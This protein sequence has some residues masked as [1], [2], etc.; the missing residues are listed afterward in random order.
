MQNKKEELMKK[1][2]STIAAIVLAAAVFAGGSSDKGNKHYVMKL[3]TQLN[4]TS[5]MVKGFKELAENVK[6]KTNGRLEIQVYPS[7]QLGTDEDVIEQA[8]QGVN[9]CVLTDAGRMGN[10]VHDIGIIG[11]AYFADKYDDVLKVTQGATFKGWVDELAT[12]NDI[13][14]LSFNW[15]DGSRSFYTHKPV[16]TPADLKGQRIRTPG[17]PAWAESVAALGG[18]PVAMPWNDTYSGIQSKAL[19][20]CEVQLTSAV[21]ARLYEVVKYL[22]KT[23][24][25]HLING[26]IV[27]EKWFKTLPADLQKILVEETQ[28]AGAKNAREVEAKGAEL[29]AEL[30]KQGMTVVNV[31]MDAFRKAADAAYDKL[32]FTALRAQIYKEIGKK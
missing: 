3:S 14:V 8:I 11:M 18:T 1:I 24:H 20:G 5:V 29:E 26:L 2:V 16:K 27:G 15:Y 6:A 13:R 9:V 23:E 7:A 4:E 30:V 25:F 19:D 31:D 10:Y 28:A 32:G 21:P 12:K 22:D 17:A